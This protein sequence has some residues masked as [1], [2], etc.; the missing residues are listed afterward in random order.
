MDDN[1][2][3]SIGDIIKNQF[4]IPL[5]QRNFAWQE[6]EIKQLILDLYQSYQRKQEAYFIGSLIVM[7]RD[8]GQ[9]WEV[10]DG[11]QRLTVLSLILKYL[12]PGNPL[13]GEPF[14]SYDSRVAVNDFLDIFHQQPSIVPDD[15]WLSQFS[16]ASVKDYTAAIYFI[17]TAPL[18]PTGRQTLLSELGE[19]EKISFCKYILEHVLMVFVEMP[20]DTD[21]ASYFEI[22]NNRGTQLQG[23]EVLKSL[24]MGRLERNFDDPDEAS[25]HRSAFSYL[26]DAC[27]DMDHPVQRN[28]VLESRE[29]TK[30]A[31]KRIFGDNY[32]GLDLSQLDIL[33]ETSSEHRAGKTIEGILS[34]EKDSSDAIIEKDEDKASEGGQKSIID[35]PNFLL[36]VFKLAYN[37][38][39]RE[40]KKLALPGQ[41]SDIANDDDFNVP[42]HEKELLNVYRDLQDDIKPAEFIRKLLFYRVVFDR[43]IVKAIDLSND[44]NAGEEPNS[45][46]LKWTLQKPTKDKSKKG[47]YEYEYIGARETFGNTATQ[48][49]VIKALSM[50]QVTFRQ[51]RYKNYLTE[52]LSWFDSMKGVDV[53]GE[54]Y[55]DKLN[56]LILNEFEKNTTYDVLR[57]GIPYDD[58]DSLWL[59]TST[60]HFLFNFID[61]LYWTAWKDN[62][63]D[64]FPELRYLEKDFTFRYFNSVEHHL[65][66]ST[67][68][69]SL[70]VIHSLGNLCLISKTMN[71]RLNAEH[72]TGKAAANGKYYRIDLPPTRKII[73]DITNHDHAWAEAQIRDHYDS[74]VKLIGSRA[75]ILGIDRVDPRSDDILRAMLCKYNLLRYPSWCS[76]GT[77]YT[78]EIDENNQDQIDGLAALKAWKTSHPLL[79]IED[80]IVEQLDSSHSL[81]ESPWKYYLIKYPEILKYCERKKIAFSG[82]SFDT[83]EVTLLQKDKIGY[84]NYCNLYYKVV[85]IELV[86]MG[87]NSDVFAETFQIRLPDNYF[88]E[89]IRDE[90]GHWR[91]SIRNHTEGFVYPASIGNFIKKD[92]GLEYV[93]PSLSSPIDRIHEVE[94]VAKTISELYNSIRLELV[95][96]QPEEL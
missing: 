72:P 78:V 37:P 65:P 47:N 94:V 46:D 63:K 43:Y 42:L 16:D 51:R 44:I 23:H 7:K 19:Q 84:Y 5:Y 89:I 64:E 14:L 81:K 91:Y 24:M 13:L 82:D 54:W 92:G 40:R 95:A 57:N 56:R 71:S 20:E 93:G 9:K 50:L 62:L 59:G 22:M 55:L 86:N 67:N 35:F 74:L 25:G 76:V 60:P 26:W 48:E 31:R 38:L 32:D 28:L 12:Y 34:E 36:H 6:P 41:S 77:R 30:E 4:V 17:S 73:Y 75:S 66:Q 79:G 69:V 90:E 61:Y 2:L 85:S 29:R 70:K 15:I 80:Y 18:N 68:N 21:V 27:S 8:D 83:A 88:M 3:L 58:D 45:E 52:I 1:M 49:R 33:C 87:I 11:Q 96:A 10:I 53:Q 39:Y